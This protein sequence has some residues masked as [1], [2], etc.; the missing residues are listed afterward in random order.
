MRR[1]VTGS[2]AEAVG[3]IVGGLLA[4]AFSIFWTVEAMSMGPPVLFGLFG[5]VCCCLSIWG[6][7]VGVHVG[8][9]NASAKP[10]DRIGFEETVDIDDEDTDSIDD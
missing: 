9:H 10:E 7:L 2:T 8:I 3:R 1:R 6:I 4:L 5:V